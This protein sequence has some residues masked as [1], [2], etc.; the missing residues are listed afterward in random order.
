MKHQ[1]PENIR[2]FRKDRKLTQ[3]QLAEAM[4]VTV[5]TVSKWESGASVP[6]LG[7][8]MDLADFFETSVDVLLGYS[9]SDNNMERMLS[10]M[11]ALRNEKRFDEAAA[12]AE[13]ALQKYPNSFEVCYKCAYLYSLRGFEEKNQRPLQRALALF[14]RSLTMIDQNREERV[15]ELSIRN[16]ISDIYLTLGKTEAA[17]AMM[18]KNNSE[19]INNGKI[20]LTLS[21]EEKTREEALPYLSS[22]LLTSETQLMQITFGYITVFRG[23]KDYR[24]SIAV[25]EWMLAL[26][27]GLRIPGNIS[28]YDH[29]VVQLLTSCMIDAALQDDL[30][31]A[32]NYLKRARAIARQFDLSPYYGFA[33]TRFYNT[34]EPITAFNDFGRTAMEGIRNQIREFPS[35]EAAL[36]SCWEQLDREETDLND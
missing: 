21:L 16:R 28:H 13:K 20:G 27:D 29:E 24:Q 10:H 6:E 17:L 32:M 1:I 26:I 8:I 14:E 18:K 4:G 12:V 35:V 23:R 36:T 2:T 22:A 34:P 33:G 11:T 5:G 25:S 15:S 9:L 19:G 31:A 30:P 7:L 3:E